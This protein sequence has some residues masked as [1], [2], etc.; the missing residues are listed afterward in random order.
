MPRETSATSLPDAP[1]YCWKKRHRPRSLS[2][3][4]AEEDWVPT[5]QTPGVLRAS[6]P[7]GM[8]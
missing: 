5:D 3:D 7:S 2:I 1:D 6:L 8:R 4:G